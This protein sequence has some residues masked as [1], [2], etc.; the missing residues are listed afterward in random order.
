[1]PANRISASLTQAQRDAVMAAIDTIS[2]NLP[3][4]IDLSAEERRD[5]LK[6][7]DKTR[8]FVVKTLELANQNPGILPANFNLEEMQ[9]DVALLEALYPIHQALTNLFD[10]IDDTY[11][12]AGSEAYSSALHVY[13]Y[14]KAANV[15]TGGLDAVL[16]DL[17]KRFARKARGGNG[18]TSA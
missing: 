6:F 17:G 16:D 7:G 15:A 4:L 12:A 2:Q 13:T 3:F 14:A 9:K 1:M 8:A 5:M 11:F 18:G 10:K